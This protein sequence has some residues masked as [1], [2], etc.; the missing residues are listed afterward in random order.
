MK[1][2]KFA[3]LMRKLILDMS[4][5][6]RVLAGMVVIS[7]G[8]AYQ[9]VAQEIVSS[10]AETKIT[11]MNYNIKGLGGL[12]GG[13][14]KENL[15]RIATEIANKVQNGTAPDIILF[16]EVFSDQSNK[17]VKSLNVPELYPYR[18][19]GPADTGGHF[20]NSGLV[21]LSRFPILSNEIVD[22]TGQCSSW[23]CNANKGAQ[24]IAVKADQW[25]ESI[26]VLN[27][28]LQATNDFDDIRKEQILILKNFYSKF[29]S[30]QMNTIFAGDFNTKPNRP[31]YEFFKETFKG[32]QNVGEYCSK[33][34]NCQVHRNVDPKL[35]YLES[36]DHQFYS[37]SNT[38][39]I[40]PIQFVRNFSKEVDD[41]ELS[42]HKAYQV[43][44]KIDWNKK[45]CM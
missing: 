29:E 1:I 19:K 25:P 17:I 41:L 40:E 7:W 33:N 24:L 4:V 34:S 36:K 28:H 14:S 6:P 13:N 35:L 12:I 2:T 10:L 43:Q 3:G 38:S 21:A 27:T 31:S 22:F 9:A 44:Y 23:D 42:D 11:V 32:F 5:K 26:R 15:K 45:G 30:I 39:S 20:Y 8:V 37:C 16:Q 18:A